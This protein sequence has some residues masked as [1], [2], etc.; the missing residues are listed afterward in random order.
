MN[1]R[2]SIPS[3]LAPRQKI[4]SSMEWGFLL[5]L[6]LVW[7]GSFFFQAI[8][9]TSLPVL[10]IV[11]LRIAIGATALW[12]IMFL[13]GHK[14][15]WQKS[16][17]TAFVLM[18]VLNNIFPFCLIVW[19]QTQIAS[20]LAAILNATTPLF[21]IIFAH[22]L[23][24]D[25]KIS[26]LR[27]CAILL[28]FGGVAVMI[29]KDAIWGVSGHM[30]GKLFAQ[31]AI[32]LAACCYALSGIFARRF[33]NMHIKPLVAACGQLS[34]A[35][36][37]LLPIL[38]WVDRPWTLDLPPI[39]TILSILALGVFSTG[40]AYILYFRIVA[41]AGAVNLLLVT[42]LVPV[43][44]LLLGVVILHEILLWRHIGGMGCIVFGLLLL[45]GRIISRLRW[46]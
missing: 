26:I 39:G 24:R 38:L 19:G 34:V 35:T 12:L 7:G 21:G 16:V 36:I 42:L 37:L 46:W 22:F 20:G 4:M 6:A 31:Y 1:V 15:V 10:T 29:G 28:G 17:W 14:M 40:F 8:A 41:G 13:L 18:G 44:A 27:F 33:Q 32:L 25:E 5:L 43:G 30:E 11:W 3:S 23:T 45:D 9:V 2:Y